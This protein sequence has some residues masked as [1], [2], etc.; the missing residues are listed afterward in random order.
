MAERLKKRRFNEVGKRLESERVR[1]EGLTPDEKKF[2]EAV[3]MPTKMKVLF[4]EFGLGVL[5]MAAGKKDEIS[6]K[7][8]HAGKFEFKLTEKK[9]EKK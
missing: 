7:I 2:A 3:W 4:L 1:L 9:E 5:E 6:V 8:P